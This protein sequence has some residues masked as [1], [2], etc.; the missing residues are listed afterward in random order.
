MFRPNWPSSG[1]QVVIVKDSAAHCNAGFFPHIV[2]TSDYF[3]YV[4][5]YEVCLWLDLRWHDIH[6]AIWY[7]IFPYVY[8]ICLLQCDVGQSSEM[9]FCVVKHETGTST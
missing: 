1:V 2:V 3:G 4:G 9:K 5:I 8:I 7:F 6:V